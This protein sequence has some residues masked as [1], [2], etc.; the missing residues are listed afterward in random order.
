MDDSERTVAVVGASESEREE[1]AS[2]LAAVETMVQA[3]KPD[4][5]RIRRIDPAVIVATDEA[6][7]RAVAA[8]EVATPTL[9]VE[10][11]PAFASV[12]RAA[13]QTKLRK[14]L[15]GSAPTVRHPVVSV[16][17]DGTVRGRILFEVLLV[18]D[19]P[20]EIS[21]FSVATSDGTVAAFRADGIV[22]AT[23]LGS[24]GYARAAGGPVLG[25][26]SDCLSVVPIAPFRT[27]RDRWALGLAS[28][29]TLRVERDEET[30]VIVLDGRDAGPVPPE[31]PLTITRDG[32]IT[33]VLATE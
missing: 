33:L 32:A 3:V 13:V 1:L 29:P 18:T 2:T 7:L 19:R 9:A 17:V 16:S 15:T 28:D 24:D 12:S 20:A 8:S 22:A 31:T 6:S 10:V 25:A 26:R 11:G 23:P 21:E 5:D 27:R 4:V 14:L 30:V